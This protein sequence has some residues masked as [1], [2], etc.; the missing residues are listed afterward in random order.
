MSTFKKSKKWVDVAV[1]EDQTDAEPLVSQLQTQKFEARIHN[2]KLLQLILFLRPPRATFRVQV[3]ANDLKVV[4]HLLE[5]DAALTPPL[6]KALHCP[7]CAALRVQ[8][9]QMTRKFLLPTIF[10]HVR[11]ILR[12]VEHEAYCGNCHWVWHLPKKFSRSSPM[13]NQPA[14]KSSV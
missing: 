6:K 11:I 5:S 1:F 14:E 7:A 4:Q 10:L 3:R 8:Y 12:I 13:S 9:P 2:D